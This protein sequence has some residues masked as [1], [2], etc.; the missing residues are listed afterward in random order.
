MI[1]AVQIPQFELQ[2]KG[3]SQ[4]EGERHPEILKKGPSSAAPAGLLAGFAHFCVWT[5]HL[6]ILVSVFA[7]APYDLSLN[8]GLNLP[9]I[10]PLVGG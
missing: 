4:K 2:I 7:I 9:C 10:V 3:A 1:N 6:G 5:P 8:Y